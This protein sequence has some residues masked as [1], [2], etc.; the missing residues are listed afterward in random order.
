[1]YNCVLHGFIDLANG[2]RLDAI[3]RVL[4]NRH[5]MYSPRETCSKQP[6]LVKTDP[7]MLR[8]SLP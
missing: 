5:H 4:R 8:F 6:F 2:R 1:M 3:Y 7:T